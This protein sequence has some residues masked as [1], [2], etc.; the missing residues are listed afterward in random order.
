[1]F[2]EASVID[3]LD[4][5]RAHGKGVARYGIAEEVSPVRTFV[6]AAADHAATIRR[7]EN[8]FGE[9]LDRGKPRSNRVAGTREPGHHTDTRVAGGK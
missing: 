3:P 8:V 2:D 4:V 7:H 6:T 5:D 9:R 1:M